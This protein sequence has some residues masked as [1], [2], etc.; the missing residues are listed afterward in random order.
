VGQFGLGERFRYILSADLGPRREDVLSFLSCADLFL[1]PSLWEGLPISILE[2]MAVGVPV[3][4]TRISAIPEA[5]IDGET[6]LLVEP[7]NAEELGDAIEK[8]LDDESLRR[9]LS[10]AARAFVFERFD[11]EAVARLVFEKYAHRS[12]K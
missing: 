6:G 11:E 9:R 10:E 4:S 3:I 12:K 8:L 5:V 2:A 7:G 1:L